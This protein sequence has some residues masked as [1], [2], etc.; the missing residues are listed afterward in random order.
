MHIILYIGYIL[1]AYVIYLWS[2]VSYGKVADTNAAQDDRPT[3]SL[4]KIYTWAVIGYLQA[5]FIHLYMNSETTLTFPSD[6]RH[7]F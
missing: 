7:V 1:C 2:R 3:K 5:R 6:T 4:P